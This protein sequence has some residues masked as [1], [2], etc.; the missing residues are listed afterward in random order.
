[1]NSTQ[2]GSL[3]L[4]LGPMF[5]GKTT[6]IIDLYNNYI[7]NNQNVAVIN[8]IGDKRYHDYKL[9]THDNVMI[10]CINTE[11]IT[12]VLNLPIIEQANIILINEGQ[13]FKDIFETT[14]QLVEQLNKTV[15]ICGLDGDFKRNKFGRLLEL[16]P[17]C[18]T[19]EKLHSICNNCKKPALFSFRV[20]NETGQ[21][22]IGNQ[23]YIPL[24]RICYCNM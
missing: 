17:F 23:N 16:I 6:K 11:C 7:S 12:D 5:S 24:C 3:H 20:S 18:D 4:I 8:Y 9:S 10:D 14:L 22:V 1:M 15:H 13:F 2:N 19:V 21:V